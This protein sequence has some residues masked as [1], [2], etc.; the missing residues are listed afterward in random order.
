MFRD[1]DKW[2]VR[3]REGSKSRTKSFDTKN[4]A[5]LFEARLKSGNLSVPTKEVE[6]MTFRKWADKWFEV[7]AKVEKSESTW[8]DDLAALRNHILP[9]IGDL[10]LSEIK[11]SHGQD[12]K[13]ALIAKG[14]K[15]KT[16]NNVLQTAKKVL[17]VAVDY[18]LIPSNPWQ[19]VKNLKVPE[20]DFD[21]WTKEESDKFLKRCRELRPEFADYVTVAIHT[22]LRWGEMKALQ[23]K[24]IDFDGNTITVCR[25]FNRKL[26]KVLPRTKNKGI[27][28]VD[29]SPEVAAIMR[30]KMLMKP[31]QFIFDEAM[32]SNSWDYIGFM[33]EKAGVRKIG[34][35]DLRHTCASQ[36]AIAGVPLYKISKHLRHRNM[37]QT[38]RYA[39]LS[40]ESMR[41]IG[42]NFG[43]PQMVRGV[44]KNRESKLVSL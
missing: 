18:E 4:E 38:E 14:R 11:K 22:G 23:R 31:D 37:K 36:L 5:A 24:D 39:H 1:R 29:M 41:G 33:C 34:I 43:G 26:K 42:E 21:F 10:R 32:T 25:T 40:A 9:I 28:R 16:V 19:L 35:H 44:G 6:Q 12:L 27:G 17:A 2:R 8:H 15:E 20:Q 13:A 30:T 7:Y 3:W